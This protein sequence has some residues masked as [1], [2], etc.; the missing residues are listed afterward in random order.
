MEDDKATL[1]RFRVHE[2]IG[3][4]VDALNHR[5][6]ESYADCWT[7]DCIFE[8]TVAESETPVS[9][10]M[11]TTQRPIGVRTE[12]RDG[13]LK[14]VSTYNRYPWLFQIPS[15]VVVELQDDRN[16]K[17]R[18]VLQV[19]S[20][21]LYLI[22]ICYDHAVKQ[23]DGKWRLAH[24]DYRPSYWEPREQM[25]GFVTRTMPDHNYRNLP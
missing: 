3:R 24:R 16:A 10:K 13:I 25:P 18:Q 23:A 11:T 7:E 8:M 19:T 22:G 15:A 12:N 2:L 6:W 21:S 4:Y 17:V 1:E 5:D 14:L 9:E 20:N